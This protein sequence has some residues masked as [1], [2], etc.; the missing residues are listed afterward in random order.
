MGDDPGVEAN[1]TPT[2]IRAAFEARDLDAILEALAPDV[3]LT[4]PI[5][6]VPFTGIDEA[7]DLFAVL[8][9]VL[10]PITYVDEIPGDPHVLHFTGQIK[11]KTLEGIDLLRF[12]DQR[13]VREITVFFRPFPAVAA[14][15]SATG[16]KLARRRGGAASA[17]ILSVAGAPVNALMRATA[18]SGPRLL[19]LERSK[20]SSPS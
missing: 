18:S 9:D 14:F 2:P 11:G 17:A 4:S 10:W 15:L 12:D 1:P 3:V 19:G 13:R 7:G 6:E 8:L 16:P 20:R 5:F